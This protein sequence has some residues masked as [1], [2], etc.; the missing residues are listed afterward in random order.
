MIHIKYCIKYQGAFDIDT[1]KNLC[2][3]CR[4]KKEVENEKV[5]RL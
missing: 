4:E 2:P 3:E 1:E 5:F